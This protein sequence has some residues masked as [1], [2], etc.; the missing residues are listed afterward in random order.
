MKN[1][2]PKPVTLIIIA[3]LMVQVLYSQDYL[4]TFTGS[5]Q[6]TT[7]ET[8]EVKNIDR[9]TT[10]TLNGT[11]TLLLTEV[12]GTGYLPALNQG[13]IIY[14]NP[15]NHASRLEFYNSS[16]GNTG[17]EIYDFSGRRLIFT[18]AQ[19]D[20]GT[21]AFTISGL[22]AGI[23]LV[24]VNTPEHIY[25]RRLVS[26]SGQNLVPELQYE[27]ITQN[28]QHGPDLKS[29]S[30]IV[31]MQY[32]EGERLVIKAISGDYAHTKSLVPT[33]SQNI[34]F[35][36]LT[37]TDGIG[38]HYDVVTIGEQVWMAEN[39]KTTHYRNGISI[40]YPG[41]NNIAWQN[42]TTGAYAWYNN[43]ITWKNS[44]GALY[45][46]YATQNTFGLCPTG[47]DVPDDEDWTRLV[48]SVIAQGYPN[49]AGDPNGAGNALKSCRQINSP[50]GGA[51]N[52]QDHPHWNEHEI[53]YG[54]DAFG[55]SGL[56]GGNR[57]SGGFFAGIGNY[58]GW[59]S[60]TA[61]S[62]EQVWYR[63]LG[64]NDGNLLRSP[65]DKAHGLSIRCIWND[66]QSPTLYHLNLEVHPADAGTTEGEG[67]YVAGEEVLLTATAN[68]H[69]EFVNWTD[70]I[71]E[72][73]SGQASFTFTMSETDITLTANFTEIIYGD[74][75]PGHPT[76]TDI[77]GNVYN[78]VLIGEQCWMKENLRTTRDADGYHINRFCYDNDTVNCDLY[79]GLYAWYT[80]MNGENSSNANPSGVRGICPDGWHIPSNN[81]FWE[82]INYIGGNEKGNEMK[83]CRQ[84]D[85][86][87]GGDCNT[88][89]H[90]RWNADDTH[91]GTDV[92]GFGGIPGGRRDP[93]GDYGILGLEGFWWTSTSYPNSTARMWNLLSYL[94]VFDFMIHLRS[95]AYSVRCV[96]S[97]DVAATYSLTLSVNPQGTGVVTG[98]GEYADG[99]AVHI[100]AT[101]LPG[102][103][104]VNWTAENDSVISNE[105][106]FVYT[107]PAEAV[108]LT[109]NFITGGP[110][111]GQ[112]C[113]G[114][115]TVTDI[116][117]NVYNTVLIGSQC[118]MKENLKT[119]K[120]VS[121]NEITRLCFNND[122]ANCNLYGGLYTWHTVMNG[123]GSSMA[124]PSG[125]RGICPD[126]WHVP[127]RA[128]W[129][130][131]ANYIG[132]TQPP[133]GNH[134][135][136]CRQEG[137]PLGDSCNTSLHPRWESHFTHYGSDIY[138]F[139]GLPAGCRYGD[140]T[141]GLLGYSGKWW[142]ATSSMF[143][144][145]SLYSSL[146]Y[147][148]GQFTICTSSRN[149]AYSLRCVKN[150]DSK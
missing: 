109:A 68:Q 133:F 101:A 41:N 69:W 2:S 65:N 115:P 87:L 141:F 81:E 117:G 92:F 136:S 71:G 94:Q 48:D 116:D 59:W 129:D 35:E 147:Y 50:F 33:Q 124:N 148:A 106:N 52:T 61:L 28:R 22:N 67:Y 90:P 79:G 13:M 8:V 18:S 112:P 142:S 145:T 9:Q 98:D 74:P 15:T 70:E 37:C 46:W 40:E 127:S 122:T 103:D 19:L 4:I 125:V 20:A 78:T 131:L 76:V 58:G 38:N 111:Y 118:W 107:M 119:T 102:Y 23:Y 36:F 77:D 86:P 123:A 93:G 91:F 121:G 104:F 47:W 60:S 16:S 146:S 143:Y 150:Y 100:T 17:I 126:G 51:C 96:R 21:H 85:S 62:A 14:P 42:D 99:K 49:Q 56:P 3:V 5:G 39:L 75:C 132:G 34:E 83:S 82:L 44:Y 25:S 29:I 84:V 32:N 88:T 12:V 7:V 66:G 26:S 144:N 54:M 43:H 130:Q 114:T 149:N 137:S 105:A 95:D 24:K 31:A 138:G 55:F 6:S 80:L 89:E 120:D 10:L 110:V 73:V 45:N 140:N 53:H 134:L 64:H 11:D 1:K 113:P 128:Q 97:P 72:E 30:N 108:T 63:H 27:G 139:S 135:K 57:Y